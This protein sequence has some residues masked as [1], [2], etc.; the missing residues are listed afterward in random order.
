VRKKI[1][2]IICAFNESSRIANVLSIVVDHPLIDETIVVDDGSTDAT[3]DV[4][5]SYKG[6]RVISHG[7]NEGKCSAIATGISCA[8]N[9][10]VML[11]DADLIRLT[12]GDISAL[13][14][15]ILTD[16]ADVSISLRSNSFWIHKLLGLD[17]TSGERVFDRALM[18][19]YIDQLRSTPGFGFET[20]MNR[21]MIAQKYRIKIVKWV[22]VAHVR[23]AEKI[24]FLRGLAA[25]AQM[26]LHISRTAS[27]RE[28]IW[29]NYQLLARIV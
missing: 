29:Q 6:A 25:E 8:R 16:I 27:F 10:L 18:A 20:L 15:P 3:R 21:L 17:F 24:G 1:S 26:I 2:C 5:E 11:L 28:I 4:V 23:K 22:C 14:E 13:A 19:N 7:T 12:Q 9:D